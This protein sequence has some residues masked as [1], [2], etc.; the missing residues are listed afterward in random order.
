VAPSEPEAIAIV[1]KGIDAMGGLEKLKGVRTLRVAATNTMITPEGQQKVES[2]S[3]MQYPDRF[4]VD[5][6]QS[7]KNSS[8]LLVGNALVVRTPDGVIG[9]PGVGSDADRTFKA[10]VQRE[11]IPVLLRIAAGELRVRIV[12]QDAAV[13]EM[14]REQLVQVT[15]ALFDSVVLGFDG[16]T[17]LLRT[18]SYAMPGDEKGPWLDDIYS[19]YRDVSGV[20]IPYQLETRRDTFVVKKRAVKEAVVNPA[21]DPA[22]FDKSRLK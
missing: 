14:S 13:K 2:V 21:F 8:V 16:A 6:T 9:S 4:R 11:V 5:V 1:Q 12:P 19:D 7:G 10:S 3:F 15:G 18:V 22:L 20:K 17:G